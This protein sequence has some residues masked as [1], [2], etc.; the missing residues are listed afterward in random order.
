MS[1]TRPPVIIFAYNRLDHLSRTLDSLEENIGALETDVIIFSDAPAQEAHRS[2]VE[3][4]RQYL[5]NQ[6]FGFKTLR[7][8]ERKINW[9]L[10]NSIINGI[11]GTLQDNEQ[12]II[13]EDDIITS[14]YFL[15]FMADAL[16]TYAYEPRVMHV[17]GYNFPISSVNLPPT[18]LGPISSCWGWGTWRRAWQHFEKNTF[19]LIQRFTPAD[20]NRFNVDGNYDF[21]SQVIQNHYGQINTWAIFWYASI[22]LADGLSIFPN[23]SLTQNIGHDGTGVH[24]SPTKIFESAMASTPIPV[25]QQEI[26]TNLEFMLR[27]KDFLSQAKG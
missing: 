2:D 18:V 22:F 26:A 7:T 27:I 6:S 19:K 16:S 8:V 5:R 14:R 17:S 20:I 10:A 25:N 4:V 9:G 3:A 13:L 12:V 11:T 24:C 1:P 21:W 15:D 23:R